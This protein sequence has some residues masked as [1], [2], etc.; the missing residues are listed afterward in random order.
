[1]CPDCRMIFRVP[2]DHDGKGV[3]CP[4]CRRMLRLPE[5]KDAV[6]QVSAPP[7][8]PIESSD[9]EVPVE[10]K[11]ASIS[12]SRSHW[13]LIGSI[14][15]ISLLGIMAI[16]AWFRSDRAKSGSGELTS[17]TAPVVDL[18]TPVVPKPDAGHET[19]N[20]NDPVL[21]RETIQLAGKFLNAG[22]VEDLLPLVY[23]PEISESRIRA[24]YASE[25][26]FSKGFTLKGVP[27]VPD[28]L[29][30]LLLCEVQDANLETGILSIHA[31]PAGP[32]VD[33]ESWVAWSEISWKELKASRTT[34]PK[35][36]RVKVSS[37]NY[38][39]FYFKD[40]TAWQSY[41]LLSADGNETLYGYVL[42]NSP[43]DLLLKARIGESGA[44]LTLLIRYPAD[45]E[46]PSQVIIDSMVHKGWTEN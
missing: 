18:H 44:R 14:L 3:V 40:E 42:R 29:K 34:E 30:P 5:V 25:G 13:V 16:L 32:K 2:R 31:T 6:S 27:T 10:S 39:N 22:S 8:S 46:S 12:L 23:H 15:G 26:T 36:F 20:L 38:Y 4:S 24:Y 28:P 35:L 33:W 1:V 19:L 7:L 11:S 9:V 43:L 37:V 41:A 45:G 17:I 21:L